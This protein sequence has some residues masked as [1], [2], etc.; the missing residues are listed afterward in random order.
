VLN[1]R[2]ATGVW[3]EMTKV[4]GR[5][6]KII[7]NYESGKGRLYSCGLAVKETDTEF[8]LVHNVDNPFVTSE[9][10]KQI[11]PHYDDEVVVPVYRG[12]AGHPVLIS[13]GV[14]NEIF[15]ERG[16]DVTLK[17]VLNRFK[18]RRVVINSNVILKNLNYYTDL[19]LAKHE[20][21]Q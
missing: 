15:S 10:C 5:K 6:S 16:D 4:A 13:R 18:V 17:N 21:D 8:A 11:A 3:S 2:Y 9:V 7:L 20:M 1:Q 14:M 12:M 19:I